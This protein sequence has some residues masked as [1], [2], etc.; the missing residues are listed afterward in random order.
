MIRLI[1]C[2]GGKRYHGDTFTYVC[3]ATEARNRILEAFKDCPYS[4]GESAEAFKARQQ[5]RDIT[6]RGG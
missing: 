1:Q 5:L 6:R 2:Q 3:D 4:T